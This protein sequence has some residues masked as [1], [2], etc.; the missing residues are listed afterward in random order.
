MVFHTMCLSYLTALA[1]S[2][3]TGI[4]VPMS[5]FM[6]N[7]VALFYT[8]LGGMKAVIW[9]DVLQSGVLVF[10]LAAVSFKLWFDLGY[11]KILTDVQETGG[12]KLAD[13]FDLRMTTR[14]SAA[15]FFNEINIMVCHIGFGQY[16]VQRFVSCATPNDAKKSV[17]VGAS[18]SLIVG[19]VFIPMIGMASISYFRGCDPVKSGKISR[20]DAIVPFL[21]QE[22]FSEIPG[23]TGVFISSAYSATLST[24]STALNSGATIFFTSIIGN[25]EIKEEKRIF[26]MRIFITSCLVAF[27]RN[28]S[29]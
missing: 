13:I 5:L 11:E 26:Y 28:L 21:V 15:W 14:S 29:F 24:I 16:F 17:W 25:V 7:G 19:G 1:L 27:F 18:V 20:I 6:L 10:S 23:M 22:I 2:T 12:N 4:S 8:M 3:V 9:T